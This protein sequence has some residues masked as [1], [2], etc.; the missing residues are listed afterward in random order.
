MA[1]LTVIEYLS[2]DGVA[3]APG[4]EGE[5][6]DDGFRHG[7]WAGPHLADHREHGTVTYLSASAF[8]FGRRTYDI[9][10]PHWPAITDPADLIAGALNSRPKYVV[11]TT[12]AEASWA[13]TTIWPDRIPDR[14]AELKK[15]H[16][17]QIVV[18]GSSNLAHTLIEH[19]LV[20]TYQLWY[21]PVVLG[22]GKRLFGGGPGPLTTL[23]L[24]TTTV[25]ATGVAILTYD[26]T[27]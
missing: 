12:L 23:R 4:H 26:K 13:G 14:V 25:T 6:T 19:D 22:G 5:D 8:L 10:V 2:L 7:G 17:C 21:H 3:Q 16:E 27:T 24:T 20:D 18:P 1:S 11:S 15:Q 9:W